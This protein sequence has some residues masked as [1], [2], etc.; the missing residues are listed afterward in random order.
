MQENIERWNKEYKA[1]IESSGTWEEKQRQ[2]DEIALTFGAELKDYSGMTDILNEYDNME[3][4]TEEAYRIVNEFEEKYDT[5]ALYDRIHA[6][7]DAILK[8]QG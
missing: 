2:L 1:V 5:E 7:T 8:K 6:A 4:R 3:E